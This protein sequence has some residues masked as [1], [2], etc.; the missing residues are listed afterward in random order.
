MRPARPCLGVGTE[1][2]GQPTNNAGGRCD[3]CRAQMPRREGRPG[4]GRYRVVRTAVI[5]D[6]LARFGPVC[7]GWER[8]PHTVDPN[9][10]TLDHVVPV[11]RGGAVDDR[12]NVRVLCITCNQRRGA[13]VLRMAGGGGT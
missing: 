2:C 13:R 6:H 3:D 8:E 12:T 7:I 9:R 4:Y 5:A 10:L 1:L 11:A